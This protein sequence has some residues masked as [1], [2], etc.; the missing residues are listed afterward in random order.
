[1][2]HCQKIFHPFEVTDNDEETF[3]LS[4]ID[5]DTNYFNQTDFKITKNCIYYDES[6][7]NREYVKVK[8]WM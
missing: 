2:E 7:F 1:M 6:K 5:P 4:D 8:K 3:L